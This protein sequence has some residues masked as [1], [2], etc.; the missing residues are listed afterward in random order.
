[1]VSYENAILSIVLLLIKYKM[2]CF[3]YPD[4]YDG[5]CQKV[6]ILSE[7]ILSLR[8]SHRFA[9][10]RILSSALVPHDDCVNM[11]IYFMSL[12]AFCAFKFL[13]FVCGLFTQI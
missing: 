12:L 8:I 3:D 6:K 10:L 1:M 11:R 9:L 7:K 5:K 13:S 4:Y 2:K